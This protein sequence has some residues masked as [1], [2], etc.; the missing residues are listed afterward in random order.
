MQKVN[1]I[2]YDYLPISKALQPISTFG[3]PMKNAIVIVIPKKIPTTT[4]RLFISK[5]K[6]SQLKSNGMLIAI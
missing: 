3:Q 1:F 5:I 2:L 6:N 4:I